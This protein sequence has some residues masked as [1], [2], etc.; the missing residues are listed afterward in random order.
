MSYIAEFRMFALARSLLTGSR[1]IYPKII[2]SI[3]GFHAITSPTISQIC[4]NTF[5]KPITPAI[6]PNC[7]FKVVGKVRRRCKDCYFVR[8]QERMYVICRTHRRHKQMSMVKRE[9]NTWILTHATQSK[10]RPW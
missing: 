2:N 7:G 4:K 1:N 9:K 3:A 5:L 10:I 6:I 8:R